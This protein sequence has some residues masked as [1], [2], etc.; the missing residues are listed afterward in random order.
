MESDDDFGDSDEGS[1]SGG[2]VDFYGV[3]IES[4]NSD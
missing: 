2:R 1:A 4:R 3:I